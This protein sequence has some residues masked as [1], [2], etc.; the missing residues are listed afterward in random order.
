MVNNSSV[1][2]DNYYNLSSFI[3][4]N[5]IMNPVGWLAGFDGAMNNWFVPAVLVCLGLVLFFAVDRV[6]RDFVRSALFSSFIM[7]LVSLLL[8]FVSDPVSGEK[9]VGWGVIVPFFVL[10]A[11]FIVLDKI[12]TR[13]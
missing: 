11:V 12:D 7:S 9:L 6:E 4:V 1:V 5:P 3:D 13:F 2:L 8:F 10:T